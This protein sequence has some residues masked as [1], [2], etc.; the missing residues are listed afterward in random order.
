MWKWLWC[1]REM[2]SLHSGNDLLNIKN[3][4][5][6]KRMVL[7]IAAVLS[8]LAGTASAQVVFYKFKFTKDSPVSILYSGVNDINEAVSSDIVGGVNANAKHTKYR[9][10]TLTGP[11]EPGKTPKTWLSAV[12]W[13]RQKV[14]PFPQKVTVVY[15]DNSED[16]IPITKENIKAVFPCLE[17][18][19]V[20]YE[21]G[22]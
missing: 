5:L 15:M 16:V 6:M 18:V 4:R 7:V 14:R 17:W 3:E 22:L 9:I 2:L 1:G 19:E 21:H 13:S 10:Q 20:D 11:I 8:L 12:F